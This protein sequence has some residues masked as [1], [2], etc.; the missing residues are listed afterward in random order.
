MKTRLFAYPL[1]AM[2]V[3]FMTGLP[4]LAENPDSAR[5]NTLLQQAKQHAVNANLDAE[6]IE[7]FTRSKLD[8]RTHSQ[9]IEHMR[10]DINEMGKDIA[11]LSEERAQGSPWQQEAIDDIN[12]LLKSMA[13]HLSAMIRHLNDNQSLVHMPPYIDYAKANYELSQKLLAMINDYVDYAETKW[14]TEAL[15]Q[16]LALAPGATPGEE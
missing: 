7:S 2:G 3:M 8:W 15:E 5:I 6:R 9:Q 10:V 12:P 13:D 1:L 14:R 16:K 4:L 11:T